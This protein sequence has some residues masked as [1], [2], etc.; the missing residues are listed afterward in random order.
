MEM[1]TIV[2]K[3]ITFLI[4]KHLYSMTIILQLVAL[5][6]YWLSKLFWRLAHSL[7]VGIRIF[8]NFDLQGLQ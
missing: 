3:S 4:I 5:L 2:A 1:C 7:P 6:L 8:F